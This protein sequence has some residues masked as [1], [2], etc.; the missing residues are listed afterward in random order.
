MRSETTSASPPSRSKT[1]NLPRRR[2]SLIRRPRRRAPTTSAGSGSVRRTH[3][4]SNSLMVRSTTSPRSCRAMVS[5]SG[6][7]GIR[8]GGDVQSLHLV[9]VRSDANV[10][11]ER[12]VELVRPAHFV[13]QESRHPFDLE[14]R[15]FGD[16]LIVNL[17]QN[18]SV[19]VALVQG[20]MHAGHR[21]LHDVSGGAL[22]RHVDRHSPPGIPHGRPAACP[23]PGVPAPPPEPPPLAPPPPQT[24]R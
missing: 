15:H 12:H 7:S 10:D 6:S 19:Q 16:E 24:I 5:T 8:G 13:A 18:A 23:V 17:Q 3:R 4:D 22:D 21:D 9:P 1:T 14:P 2:T 20:P 11:D